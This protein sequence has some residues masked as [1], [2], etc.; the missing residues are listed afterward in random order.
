MYF[1]SILECKSCH[2]T[3]WL[4]PPTEA[5]S[6]PSQSPWRW[7]TGSLNVA[8]LSCKQAFEYSEPDC[9]W[10]LLRS[11]QIETTKDMAAHQ[12][13]IACESQQCSGLIS[14]LVITKR[15][16]P[17]SESS[18]IAATLIARGIQ[19]DRGHKNIGQSTEASAISFEELPG[20]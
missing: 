1:L 15:G 17:Q 16:L 8:C 4:P 3:I 7:G 12:L 19:C 14:I 13:V 20:F 18:A 2:R 10:D 11:R 5:N 9:R 6:S